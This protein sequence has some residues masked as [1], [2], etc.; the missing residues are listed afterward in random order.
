MPELKLTLEE[1]LDVFACVQTVTNAHQ[2][3]GDELSKEA[4]IDWNNLK[5]VSNKLE[6]YIKELKK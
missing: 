6:Y 4:K 2:L 1:I 3:M 5:I